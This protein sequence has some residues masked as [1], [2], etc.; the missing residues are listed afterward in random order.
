MSSTSTIKQQIELADIVTSLYS[1]GHVDLASDVVLCV[2]SSY[3]GQHV[4]FDD[5]N[6]DSV[7]MRTLHELLDEIG[8]DSIMKVSRDKALHLGRAP[9]TFNTQYPGSVFPIKPWG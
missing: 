5:K 2:V 8:F 4:L 6:M 7:F 3:N 1:K 9:A